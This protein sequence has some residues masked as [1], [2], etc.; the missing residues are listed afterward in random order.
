MRPARRTCPRQSR[1]G[2]VFLGTSLFLVGM[3]W[4]QSDEEIQDITGIYQF[5]GANDTLALLE[6]EGQLKGYVDVVQG[7][8][9]SDA[10]LSYPISIGSRRKDQVEFK[11]RRIQQKY[12]RFTGTAQHGSGREEA[13]PDFL[14]LVGKLEIITVKAETGE[15]VSQQMHVVFKSLGREKDKE[16]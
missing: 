11:T 13:N 10:V 9:E 16:E 12:F 15:E 6:E 7:D 5:L 8:E 2:F 3:L 4:A 1:R 14:R